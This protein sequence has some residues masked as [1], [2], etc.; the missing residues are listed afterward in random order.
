MKR[1]DRFMAD[2]HGNED[3]PVDDNSLRECLMP[4]RKTIIL[5]AVAVRSD[6]FKNPRNSSQIILVFAFYTATKYFAMI[7]SSLSNLIVFKKI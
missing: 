4:A 2:P 7:Q 1:A 6:P 5:P 3:N